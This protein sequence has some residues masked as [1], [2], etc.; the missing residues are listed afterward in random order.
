MIQQLSDKGK[1]GIYLI[2]NTVNGKVYVGKALCIYRRIKNHVGALNMKSKDENRHLINAWFKYGRSSFKYEVLEYLDKNESKIA[3]RELYWMGHYSSLNRKNGYNLRYDS[4]TGLIVSEETREKLRIA[5]KR[6][7]E[8]PKERE[9]VGL[10]SKNFWKNNPDIKKQM[11]ENVSK[12]KEK[13]RFL[14]YSKE[15]NFIKTWESVSSIIQANPNY[16]WQNIYSVCN[17]YKKTYMGF[18]WTKELKI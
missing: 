4:S 12:S 1:S 10:C 11:S 16:K 13:Y 7:F 17:G 5:T 18:V 6:R 15:E 9:K 3:E 8:D 2:M 14:Q